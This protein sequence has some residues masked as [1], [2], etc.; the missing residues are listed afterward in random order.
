MKLCVLKGSPRI[1]GNTNS[2]LEPF[3]EEAVGKGHEVKQFDLYRMELKP[4][5][6]CR[7]CQKDWTI[8]GCPIKDGMRTIFDTILESDLILVATPIYSWFC[9]GPMKNTLDRMVYGMNKYYG[10][11]KGPSLWKGKKVAMVITCGYKAEKGADL[12]EEAMKRYCKH[13]QLEYLG[14]L[15]ERHMGYQ[16]KFMDGEKEQHAREFAGR[17]VGA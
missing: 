12:F 17:I 11:E 3:L 1:N 5:V 4:C 7:C 10:E 6:A 8:F 9:T 2:L 14:M 15:C 16:T 13:S